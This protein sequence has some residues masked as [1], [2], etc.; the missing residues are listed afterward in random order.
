VALDLAEL[1]A[2]ASTAVLTM[3]L[4][5]GVVGD[6]A[7]IPDLAAEVEARGVLAAAGRLAAA[8]REAGVPVV[9]CTAQFRPDRAG[10][11]TNAPLLAVM[12]KREQHLLVGSPE[13]E[14]VPELGPDPRDL[15]VPRWS[16]VSP[17]A[18]TALDVTLRNLGERTVVAAGVSVNLAVLGLAIEAVN[19][20]YRVVVATDAVAGTPAD[21]ADAVLDGT[22]ALLATRRTVDEIAGVWS[23]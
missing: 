16:G 5:R 2:P 8:A 15:V 23:R 22:I 6:R 20:G 11:A 19:L 12:A 7:S 18:G 9:H 10:S 4:Q 14:V 21:Y 17:F 3:E 13:A 1:L